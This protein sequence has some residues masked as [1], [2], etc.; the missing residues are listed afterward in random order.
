MK[1]N[2]GLHAEPSMGA[3]QAAGKSNDAEATLG[4]NFPRPATAVKHAEVVPGAAR[5]AIDQQVGQNG[6]GKKR[7]ANEWGIGH[8]SIADEQAL[9]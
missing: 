7:D 9:K 6:N 1:K 3:T 8:K 2:D 4:K 5:K